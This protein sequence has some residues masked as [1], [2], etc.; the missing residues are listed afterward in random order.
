MGI[1]SQII[2]ASMLRVERGVVGRRP[3]S[4]ISPWSIGLLVL[5]IFDVKGRDYCP[6]A[7]PNLN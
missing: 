4:P 7:R 6:S 1:R 2:T 5:D 3:P